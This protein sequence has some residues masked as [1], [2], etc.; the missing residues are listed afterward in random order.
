MKI[1][2]KTFLF[3]AALLGGIAVPAGA[4]TLVVSEDTSVEITTS[5]AT[6]YVIEDGATLTIYVEDSYTISGTFLGT[7][8]SEDSTDFSLETY[9]S[10]TE[11]Y[12]GTIVISGGGTLGY[13]GFSDIE[14]YTTSY[15]ALI[16]YNSTTYTWYYTSASTDDDGFYSNYYGTIY[17]GTLVSDLPSS[18]LGSE[19]LETF[20]SS[21]VAFSGTIIIEDETTLIVSGYLSQ[22]VRFFGIEGLDSGAYVGVQRVELNG[23]ATI[24]FASSTKNLSDS[25]FDDSNSS[26][27]T[28]ED[29]QLLGSLNFLVNVVASAQSTIELGSDQDSSLRLVIYTSSDTTDASVG[30]LSG[31]GRV[32]FSGGEIAILNQ[33]NFK[34]QNTEHYDGTFSSNPTTISEILDYTAM[35]S[36]VYNLLG[37][38]VDEDGTYSSAVL[39][40]VFSYVATI[41]LGSAD[42]V[43]VVDNVLA[44]ATAIQLGSNSL[45]Y[46]AID[47]G[48]VS[49]GTSTEDYIY[50][51]VG[52]YVQRA[53][54]GNLVIYGTQVLNNLQSLFVERAQIVSAYS[55]TGGYL[56]IAVPSDSSYATGSG[57][58]ILMTESSITIINQLEDRDGI[59]LGTFT[60]EYDSILVKTGAGTFVNIGS[61]QN[62]LE[63]L[64][65]LEG[66]WI[67]SIPK[68]GENSHIIVSGTGSLKIVV[69]DVKLFNA[70]ISG[71]ADFYIAR[72]AE[73]IVNDG[74]EFYV[75]ASSVSASTLSSS[76]EGYVVFT[77]AQDEFY[78]N[79][80]IQ[81]GITVT[82]GS[83]GSNS[84]SI[85]SN[86]ESITLD[87]SATYMSKL[88]IY[89][90]Q[91]ITNLSGEK[92]SSFVT[93][94]DFAS[95]VLAQQNTDYN[96]YGGI[97][98]S[99]TIVKLGNNSI[100]LGASDVESSFSGALVVL[101]GTTSINKKNTLSS[102]AGVVLGNAGTILIN[103]IGSNE[104]ILGALIG[105]EETYV[106]AGSS[107]LTIGLSAS[108]ALQIK[109]DIETAIAAGKLD[110]V[111]ASAFYLATYAGSTR[112]LE[113]LNLASGAG[114]SSELQTLLGETLGSGRP[115]GVSVE[116]TLEY[117]KDPGELKSAFTQLYAT[118]D[119]DTFEELAGTSAWTSIFGSSAGTIAEVLENLLDYETIY[120]FVN[121]V[122]TTLTSRQAA[123]LLELAEQIKE[124]D[125]SV[126]ELLDSE[127]CFTTSTWRTLVDAYFL[128]YLNGKLGVSTDITDGWESLYDFI[129]Y[130]YSDYSFRLT[131][132]NIEI[133]KNRYGFGTDAWENDSLYE[134]FEDAIGVYTSSDYGPSF[135][136][137][138]SGTA[139]LKKI[140]T[141]SLTLTGVN[142]YS[143]A[144]LVNAGELRIDWDAIQATEYIEV[145]AGA[146]LTIVGQKVETVY[147]A[148]GSV[149]EYSYTN[150]FEIDA[151][152]GS[153]G[154]IRGEGV[155]LIDADDDGVTVI[156]EKALANDDDFTG[157]IILGNANLTVNI[158]NRTVFSPDVYINSGLTFRIDF[159]NLADEDEEP[160]YTSLNFTGSIYGSGTFEISGGGNLIFEDGDVF[161]D[162]ENNAISFAISD[163]ASIQFNLNGII[164]A[165]GEVLS[166][167][168]FRDADTSFVVAAG[169]T[170]AFYVESNVE[171]ST[172][173]NF[174]GDESGAGT[175]K[176][177]GE[178]SLTLSRSV[179]DGEVDGH[180]A[181]LEVL[182]GTL[183]I[184]ISTEYVFEKVT[185]SAGTT[186]KVSG[187]L[188][189]SSDEDSE[190]AGTLSGAGTI[191]KSGAGTLELDGEISFSGT[192]N[193]A[194]GT[195]KIASEDDQTVSAEILGNADE[196]TSLVKTGA[197]RVDLTG[198]LDW[199]NVEVSVQEGILS[200]IVKN[201][202]GAVT[203]SAENSGETEV[204]A[205]SA[206]QFMHS[207]E[208]YEN[209][210]LILIFE[211]EENI[212]LAT[213]ELSGSGTLE[214]DGEGIVD[215]ST[216]E[217]AGD[218]YGIFYVDTNVTLR[219]GE[220]VS[221]LSGIGGTGTILISAGVSDFN[222][223][224]HVDSEFTGTLAAEDSDTVLN[225]YGP[226]RL[227]FTEATTIE[228]ISQINIGKN[229]T[230][231]NFGITT[232]AYFENVHVVASQSSI[233]VTD[234]ISTFSKLATE[235]Q[236]DSAVTALK[237]LANGEI[238]FSADSEIL[239]SIF[240]LS[241][242][243]LDSIELT[244]SN[245]STGT[246]TIFGISK[247]A[248]NVSI[249]VVDY[250]TVEINVASDESY[251]KSISGNGNLEKSG[252]GTLTISADSH[253]YTGETIVSEGTLH[254]ESRSGNDKVALASSA[255]VVAAGATISGGIELT[256]SD[257]SLVFGNVESGTGV[258][259]DFANYE[260]NI[261][262]GEAI[263]YSGTISGYLNI[264][265]TAINAERGKAYT[266]IEFTGEEGTGTLEDLTLQISISERSNSLVFIDDSG[267]TG[268]NVVVYVSQ[269]HITKI[270]GLKIHEGLTGT[271]LDLLSDWARPDSRT[272]LLTG[273]DDE[274]AIG[275]A[276]NKASTSE[277]YGILNNLS[278]LGL[279]STITMLHSSWLSDIRAVENRLEQRL[280]DNLSTNSI[281]VYEEDYEVF[282][283]AQA[284]YVSTGTGKSAM[285]FDY[286]TYGALAGVDVKDSLETSYG[287]A[288]AYDR[289]NAKI[290]HD[291]GKIESDNVRAIAFAGTL[292]TDFV[293]LN[294]G[295]EIGY[296]SYDVKRKTIFGKTKGDTDALHGGIFADFV[297]AFQ[298]YDS[299]K[300]QLDLLP[301]VGVEVSYYNVGGFTESGTVAALDVDR[302]DALSVQARIGAQLNWQVPI[303]T[304]S[305]R[306]SFDV[307]YL[308]EIANSEV[309]IEAKMLGSKFGIAAKTFTESAL[310]LTPGVAYDFD[311]FT[312]IF[313]NYEF[314]LGTDSEI[315]HSVHLGFRHRF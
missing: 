220:D 51:I 289:G 129:S 260:V 21:S 152:N 204:D 176:K 56:E 123:Q 124:N 76:N 170:L 16:P 58:K 46:T 153:L 294:F 277:L 244:L 136:G 61:A 133:L 34:T 149:L 296:A 278:P 134:A 194:A 121:S 82:L 298:I 85:F 55:E 279:A 125:G 47:A 250:G 302:F 258:D 285:T 90:R 26:Y 107:Q 267:L 168:N 35:L 22:F 33:A 261:S 182:G 282:A 77:R 315:G 210:K 162:V 114:I 10:A 79:L 157:S 314:K 41:S 81:S 14:Y 143:G 189:V 4:E 88:T 312:S 252:A 23:T 310:T 178:G 203:I 116:T 36:S 242:E 271:F 68:L 236:I 290:H 234:E 141:E 238:N 248:E 25:N 11:S 245:Y 67:T 288:I 287:V 212:D 175:L 276:I 145:A 241:G 232:N 218:F 84:P 126:S 158:E 239:T 251:E 201:L 148:D 137:T 93:L 311:G 62:T 5:T 256:S 105:V 29:A 300:G 240:N 78:G 7:G 96:Y 91:I 206:K 9:T 209:S 43:S 179:D 115:Y 132:A 259:D 224:V 187:T 221:T 60:A 15:L 83:E 186:F 127:G 111:S 237:L 54:Y 147:D 247:I 19:Y 103:T 117:L 246:L 28:A 109:N 173:M 180:L 255:L 306:L 71:D 44:T 273:T 202:V 292:L 98:G 257:A 243:N 219:L 190:I 122:T 66:T 169:T 172:E 231:G 164:D 12:T 49:A 263:S 97:T 160:V 249:A 20:D 37:H 104:Q 39:A 52:S 207:A 64:Y 214:L 216:T 286:Q 27:S 281:W 155:I 31:T 272:G 92:A 270:D 63:K 307:S 99:G 301:H 215:L 230:V 89:S 211:N 163:G 108:D 140:G 264:V 197:G 128:Q 195:L 74:R 72:Y 94:T 40:D 227:C 280:Y 305:F 205:E 299:E 156:F 184:L 183:E 139:I 196:T 217:N 181:A 50:T 120:E 95:L 284:K 69:N 198:T 233:A 130:F 308:H 45:Y 167:L 235:F 268:G 225:I 154:T 185:T 59:Y 213:F 17:P 8:S 291:G 13:S 119:A 222:L 30:I 138:I 309:D 110:A 131:A 42:G 188:Y 228:N 304:A 75:N 70:Q 113:T 24:S 208:I 3:A 303:D 266:V 161:A 53:T 226:G 48:T 142:T 159:Q 106:S 112:Y 2:Q 253:S 150:Y 151:N 86:A 101:D 144:T 171:Y 200:A 65:I 275:A 118:I 38:T 229:G 199:Q 73:E 295:A 254:F 174:I 177:L 146:L 262:N 100:S 57:S 269:S 18:L 6:N 297:G 274:N 283:Q 166:D 223:Y 165:T 135:D 80:T 313:L 193:L 87:G 265:V 191:E 1:S 102:S 32:Y 192:I 293:S